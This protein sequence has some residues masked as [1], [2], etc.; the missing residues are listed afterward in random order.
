MANKCISAVVHNIYD[1]AL[2]LQGVIVL[3]TLKY[4]SRYS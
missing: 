2:K 1:E 4:L 3:H